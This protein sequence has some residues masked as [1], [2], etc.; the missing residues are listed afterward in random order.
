MVEIVCFIESFADSET[1]LEITEVSRGSILFSIFAMTENPLSRVDLRVETNSSETPPPST[2]EIRHVT[3]P[4]DGDLAKRRR[5]SEI[6]DAGGDGDWRARRGRRDDISAK[7][8]ST[9]V[10]AV[11]AIDEEEEKRA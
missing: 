1:P 9:K 3:F 11:D 8:D 5:C 10:R 6:C 2:P 4:E 7:R